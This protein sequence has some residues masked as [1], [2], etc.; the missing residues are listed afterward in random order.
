MFRRF[1]P[2][3]AEAL[4]SL[5]ADPIVL[6]FTGDIPFND[7]LAAE[8]F[9]RN[10]DHYDLHGFGRWAVLLKSTKEFIGWSGL[11]YNSDGQ[12]DLGFRFFQKYW[13]L[14]YATESARACIKYGFENRGLKE[15]IGRCSTSHQSSKRVLEKAG[16][17]FWK[18]D[19]DLSIGAIQIFRINNRTR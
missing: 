3:D 5:N 18:K 8:D 1:L 11:K 2:T 19:E 9:I 10:Y 13:K 7:V 17:T 14:G 12:V 16:M 4:F 6:K 15:I